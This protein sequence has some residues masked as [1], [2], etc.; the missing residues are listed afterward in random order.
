MVDWRW[1]FNDPFG[2]DPYYT[3]I[4]WNGYYQN[5]DVGYL[6]F[7]YYFG[8]LGLIPFCIFMYKNYKVCACYFPTSQ[9]LFYYFCY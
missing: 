2:L 8:L 6:R 9:S 4:D 7:I 5:T 1:I 3:G